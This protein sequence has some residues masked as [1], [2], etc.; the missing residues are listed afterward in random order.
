MHL[1]MTGVKEYH[2][3]MV[4][5]AVG[6]NLGTNRGEDVVYD[7]RRL[8]DPVCNDGAIVSRTDW[9][10]ARFYPHARVSWI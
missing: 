4:R 3:R 9:K 6:E 10:L 2:R 7:P 8:S 5:D 1:Y